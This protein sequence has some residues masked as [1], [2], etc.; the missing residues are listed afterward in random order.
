MMVSFGFFLV[1]SLFPFP[2]GGEHVAVTHDRPVPSGAETRG[3]TKPQRKRL[4]SGKE[5]ERVPASGFSR[6][7]FWDRNGA[8]SVTAKVNTADKGGKVGTGRSRFTGF[9]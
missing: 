2:E 3:M 9:P 1:S 5:C 7:L 8:A 6:P 4:T